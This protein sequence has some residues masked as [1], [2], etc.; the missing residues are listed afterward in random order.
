MYNITFSFHDLGR[1]GDAFVQFMHLRKQF[2]VDALHWDVPNDGQLEMDQYDNPTAVYSLVLQGNRLIGG[3]R[4]TPTDATWGPHS[5]MLRDA[6]L[7]LLPGIPA[8]LLP[9]EIRSGAVWECTRLVLDDNV[10]D[11]LDRRE[12]LSLIVRGLADQARLRGGTE[13][14]SLSPVT[15]MRSLRQ[16]GFGARRLS[17]PYKNDDG[18]SYAVL[19]MPT[20]YVQVELQARAA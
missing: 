2:F 13:L 5:Y 3:A 10:T 11:G 6:Q 4:M 17:A 9:N 7:G 12:C 8:N 14:M 1:H 18:R 15:L 20:D 16:L 19:A